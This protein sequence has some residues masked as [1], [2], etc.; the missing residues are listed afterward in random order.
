MGARWAGDDPL[1]DRAGHL[2][3]D[4]RTDHIEPRRHSERRE[5]TESSRCD[6]RCYRVGGVMEA[7][8]E[9]EAQRDNYEEDQAGETHPSI[10][11]SAG[12]QERTRI[13]RRRTLVRCQRFLPW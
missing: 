1:A 10:L 11:S 5:G 8:G 13:T 12:A 6:R 7:V 2:G 4:E 9:V 3:R